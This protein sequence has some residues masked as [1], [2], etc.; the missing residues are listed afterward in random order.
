MLSRGEISEDPGFLGHSKHDKTHAQRGFPNGPSLMIGLWIGYE[1][2]FLVLVHIF[3]Q[4]IWVSSKTRSP[5]LVKFIH[6]SIRV[7]ERVFI[8]S[9]TGSLAFLHSSSFCVQWLS[10]CAPGRSGEDRLLRDI[11]HRKWQWV[12]SSIVW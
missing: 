2:Q 9:T 8:S 5:V 10:I 7:I 4:W 6:T 3:T 12:S 1:A 11:H